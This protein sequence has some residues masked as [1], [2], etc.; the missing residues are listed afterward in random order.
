M[1]VHIWRLEA[2]IRLSF[3]F[4]FRDW[5]SQRT[6]SCLSGLDS[7]ASKSWGSAHLHPPAHVSAWLWGDKKS[8][9]H[10]CA[11]DTLSS[12]P[13]SQAI[14]SAF[15]RKDQLHI[16]HILESYLDAASSSPKNCSSPTPALETMI[17]WEHPFHWSKWL[18]LGRCPTKLWQSHC[19]GYS[20]WASGNIFLGFLGNI[21]EVMT[22]FP[23]RIICRHFQSHG[24]SYLGRVKTGDRS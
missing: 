23:L 21:P 13:S 12:E 4:V 5:T 15:C 16:R 7:L 18:P 20:H 24:R 6:W 8:G 10:A 11:A 1:C 2:D 19:S 22:Y 9:P 3:C 17:F 14:I